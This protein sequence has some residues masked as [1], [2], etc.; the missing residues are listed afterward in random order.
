MSKC[1]FDVKFQQ[2]SVIRFLFLKGIKPKDIQSE[3]AEA[4]GY[5]L[6]PLRTIYYWVEKFRDGETSVE[7]GDRG[8]RPRILGLAERIK[9]FLLEDP[10]ASAREMS[11]V[12]GVDKN[13]VVRVLRE[14]LDMLKVNFRWIPHTLSEELKGIRV[15]IAREM[16]TILESSRKWWDIYILV[17]KLG[18]ISTTQEGPC[19]FKVGQSRQQE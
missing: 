4:Y 8:G 15:S 17:M 16:L 12:I 6:V 18:Y 11:S 14:D 1:E 10:Y 13:T 9:E 5:P 7:D 3:L 2:R 19:G